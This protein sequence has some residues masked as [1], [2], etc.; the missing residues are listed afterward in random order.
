MAIHD[1][2]WK[3]LRQLRILLFIFASVLAGSEYLIALDEYWICFSGSMRENAPPHPPAGPWHL[4]KIDALGNVLIP[5]TVVVRN[6]SQ[7]TVR[8]DAGA[9]LADN[10]M[11]GLNLWIPT[12][13]GQLTGYLYRAVIEKRS[14]K[15]LS[16]R[17]TGIRTV[18]REHLQVTQSGPAHFLATQTLHVNPERSFYVGYALSPDGRLLG[19]RWLLTPGQASCYDCGMG[20]NSGGRM[21]YF[22]ER[23]EGPSRHRVMLQPLDESGHPKGSPYEVAKAERL[24]LQDVSGIIQSRW[25][26]VL[27]AVDAP[28]ELPGEPLFLSVV[29]T[30]THKTVGDR[31]RVATGAGTIGQNAAIDPLG[32][33]IVYR[34]LRFGQHSSVD[35][36]IFQALD[37][38]GHPSGEPKVIATGVNAGIDIL[39]D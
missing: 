20:V 30:R 36:L 35:W 31:I 18:N 13:R 29:D 28:S 15:L 26:Y 24:Y 4:M 22:A 39:K 16:F 5:P 19:G 21:F 23:Q 12:R 9:A 33:F 37:A 32:R 11:G 7:Y 27:Y 14:L 1:W 8:P 25:R 3:V 34:P 6:S 38:T 17:Q 2:R 10:G